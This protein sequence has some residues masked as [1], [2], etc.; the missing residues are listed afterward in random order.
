MPLEP[1]ADAANVHVHNPKSESALQACVDQLFAAIATVRASSRPDSEAD[2]T[3]DS[4][5]APVGA[6]YQ[7]RALGDRACCPVRLSRPFGRFR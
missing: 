4:R 1:R 7:S 2:R 3:T 6:L 5:L